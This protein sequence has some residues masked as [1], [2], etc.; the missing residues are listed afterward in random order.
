MTRTT[1]QVRREAR[2]LK[3]MN[4]YRLGR[5]GVVGFSLAGLTRNQLRAARRV[6]R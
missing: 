6:G 4:Q 1:N 2:R 5:F 3:A